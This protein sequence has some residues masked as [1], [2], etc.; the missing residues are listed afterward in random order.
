MIVGAAGS[1][2][3]DY[4]GLAWVGS[5]GQWM[6]ALMDYNGVDSNDMYWT[7]LVKCYPGKMKTGAD[8]YPAAYAIEACHKW[9]L[10]EIDIVDPELI[11]AVGA[12]VMKWFKIKGGIKQ[13]NGKTF[14]TEHGRVL[15]VLNPGDIN[16]RMAEAPQFATALR[17][18]N[19]QLADPVRV[20]K[21]IEDGTW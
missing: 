4:E 12:I 1:R 20:P 7:Y 5:A 21:Y 19:A 17:A 6:S 11:V 2:E 8:Y 9:L 14:D 16:K 10:K 3:E 13:N 15:V 18:I